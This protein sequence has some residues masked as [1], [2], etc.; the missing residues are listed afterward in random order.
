MRELRLVVAELRGTYGANATETRALGNRVFQLVSRIP[1]LRATVVRLRNVIL[2][3]AVCKF[4]AHRTWFR[5]WR[6]TVSRGVVERGLREGGEVLNGYAEPKNGWCSSMA[7]RG[8][9]F[10]PPTRYI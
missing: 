3:A 2:H 8:Y 9:V 4:A 5:A 1:F 7:P 10:S 6:G